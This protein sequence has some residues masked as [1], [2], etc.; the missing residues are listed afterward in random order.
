MP[1]S[2]QLRRLREGLNG[3][4]TLG[5][6]AARLGREGT[7]LLVILIA[8]PFLQPLP[9]GG[10]SMPAGLLIAAA[11]LQAARGADRLSLPRLA[12]ERRLEGPALRGLLGLAERIVVFLERVSRP[13]GPAW[14]RSPRLLGLAIA[15][16][17]FILALPFYLPLA[18]MLCALPL[19]LLGLA[20]IEEDGASGLLGLLAAAACVAYH[21]AAARL[22]WDLLRALARRVAA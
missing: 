18:A 17:G 7:G 13:R 10:L 14:A 1:A 2:A 11:G 12:A 21:V 5:E 6:L 4:L 19:I 8:T 16:V 3:P 22:I 20:L 15:A 9:M